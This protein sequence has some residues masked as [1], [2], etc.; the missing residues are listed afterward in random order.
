MEQSS[1]NYRDLI[2]NYLSLDGRRI[3]EYDGRDIDVEGLCGTGD[4]SETFDKSLLG[5]AINDE[6]GIALLALRDE[7]VIGFF[8]GEIDVDSNVLSSDYTC[9][10]GGKKTG[11]LLRYCALIKAYEMNQMITLMVGSAS[12]GIPAIEDGDSAEVV[13]KKN[14]A[15]K[16]YHLKRGA[17][18]IGKE[19]TYTYT[20]V[21]ENIKSI[22]KSSATYKK[23]K[24]KRLPKKTRKRRYKRTKR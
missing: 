13:E 11:E 8:V 12:G 3:I 16:K 9:A 1:I 2:D 19:F 14:D 23:K 4:I 17:N 6:E 7:N 20:K 5:D 15:L 18:L 22:T 24:K 21:C 10:N